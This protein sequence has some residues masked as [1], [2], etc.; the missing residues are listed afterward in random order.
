MS[1]WRWRF[2]SM[3]PAWWKKNV[4]PGVRV[5]TVYSLE[6]VVVASVR[7]YV[8]HFRTSRPAEHCLY[9]LHGRIYKTL[10]R[11]RHTHE[12]LASHTSASICTEN[13]Y[14]HT[15]H[16]NSGIPLAFLCTHCRELRSHARTCFALQCEALVL[17]GA[18]RPSTNAVCVR[19]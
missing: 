7:D 10:K 11:F 17:C 13:M 5:R 6:C 15:T 18:T 1:R 16:K 19:V 3:R 12:P 9:T 4:H 2:N 14:R 8:I